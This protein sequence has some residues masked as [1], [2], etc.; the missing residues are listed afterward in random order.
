MNADIFSF[1]S[2]FDFVTFSWL[3]RERNILADVLAKNEEHR[4]FPCIFSY[5]VCFVLPCL[6][7]LI[8]SCESLK[9]VASILLK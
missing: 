4:F 7:K 9:I 8:S 1:V 3:P 6:K 5:G 2:A